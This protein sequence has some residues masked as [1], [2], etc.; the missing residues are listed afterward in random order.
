MVFYNKLVWSFFK[1]SIQVT[2][3]YRNAL[4]FFKGFVVNLKNTQMR[5]F[6][7]HGYMFYASYS[8]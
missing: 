8:S 4:L 6:F 3:C 7:K 2:S 5:Y 1:K